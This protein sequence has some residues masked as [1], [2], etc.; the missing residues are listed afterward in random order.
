MAELPRLSDD[1]WVPDRA[2]G[3]EWELRGEEKEVGVHSLLPFL[4][5]GRSFGG[6]YPRPVPQFNGN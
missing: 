6:R 4:F 3:A 1:S 5:V 2:S